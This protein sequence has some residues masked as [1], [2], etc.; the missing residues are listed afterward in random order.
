MTRRIKKTHSPIYMP[1]M[2]EIDIVKEF[3]KNLNLSLCV[4]SVTNSYSMC[5]EYVKDWFKSK[6]KDNYFKSEY[7]DGMNIFNFSQKFTREQMA[8]RMK[9][10]LSII[11]QIDMDYNRETVDLY[12][13]GTNLYYNRCDYRDAFFK[14]IDKDSYISVA[15]RIMQMNFNFKIKVSSKAH[16]IDLAEFIKLSFRCEGTQAK[17]IDMDFHIPTELMVRLAIDNGFEVKNNEVVESAAFLYYLNSNSMLPFM[18]KFRNIKGIYEYFIR[19]PNMYIHT[20]TEN[21]SVDDGEREAQLNNNFVVEF[22]SVVRFPTPQFYAYYSLQRK[23]L[24]RGQNMDGSYTVYEMFMSKIPEQNSK[25][26]NQYLSVEYEMD[27]ETS[28]KKEPLEIDLTGLFMGS[29][30]KDASDY[31]KS[32]FLNPSVFTDIKLYNNC[33]E[34]PLTADWETYTI[35]TSEPVD[36]MKSFIIVYADLAYIN[37]HRINIKKYLD[38]RIN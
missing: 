5:I 27:E 26:W 24:I 11:P 28:K 38:S 16:A 37:D 6:F 8:K 30:L 7:I 4:P 25:G 13:Y 12:N 36:N 34:Y 32:I 21:V 23:E 29:T 31:T 1:E 10:A 35:K 14:D 20:R 18:Y 2:K 9:P 33:K 17:Y 15:M 3:R 22:N 19:M